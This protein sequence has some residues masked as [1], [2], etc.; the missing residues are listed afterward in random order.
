M[1]SG[2]GHQWAAT[3]TQYDL[4]RLVLGSSKVSLPAHLKD[5]VL[6]HDLVGVPAGEADVEFAVPNPAHIEHDVRVDLE[7]PRSAKRS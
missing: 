6:E 7:Q 1:R 4:H 2:L 5:L 3:P